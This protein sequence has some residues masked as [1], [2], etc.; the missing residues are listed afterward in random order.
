MVCV[1]I[2]IYSYICINIFA[3]V[4]IMLT[5]ENVFKRVMESDYIFFI[6]CTCSSSSHL[7]LFSGGLVSLV[8]YWMSEIGSTTAY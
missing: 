8:C 6:L 1:H 2:N 3:L 7:V 4:I 5:K